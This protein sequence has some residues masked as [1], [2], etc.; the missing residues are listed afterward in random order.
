MR[1]SQINEF[2]EINMR[3]VIQVGTLAVKRLERKTKKK[4]K[5]KKKGEKI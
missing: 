3:S 4:K 2:Y 1:L 5:G